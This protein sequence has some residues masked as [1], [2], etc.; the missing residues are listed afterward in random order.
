MSDSINTVSNRIGSFTRV[1]DCIGE[2]TYN[3]NND[4]KVPEITELASQMYDLMNHVPFYLVVNLIH[5][6]GSFPDGVWK[7]IGTDKKLNNIILGN[8]VVT[9]DVGYA[10]QIKFFVKKYPPNYPINLVGTKTEA[11]KWIQNLKG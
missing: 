11:Y 6:L 5:D 4:A 8:A 9:N 2:I 3:G 10:M 7:F 1:N